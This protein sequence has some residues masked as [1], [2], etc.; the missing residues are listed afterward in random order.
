MINLDFTGISAPYEA[1]GTPEIHI[2]TDQL[3]VEGSVEKIVEYLQVQ[4]FI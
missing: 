2:H 3:S 1:P 4:K